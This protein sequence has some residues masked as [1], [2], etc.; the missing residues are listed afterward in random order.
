MEFLVVMHL[1]A[2]TYNY[3]C[4]TGFSLSCIGICIFCILFCTL[5]LA[6]PYDSV[7]DVIFPP[8][9]SSSYLRM[10]LHMLSMY[11][12]STDF[13]TPHSRNMH[14]LDLQ[15]SYWSLHVNFP[16]SFMSTSLRSNQ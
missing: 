8:E 2:C 9:L 14:S 12:D 3:L 13:P 6:A 1:S 4:F 10:C 5:L 15:K 7:L 16:L 11:C